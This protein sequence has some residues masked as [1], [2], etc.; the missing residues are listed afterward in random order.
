[1]KTF[2]TAVICLLAF[3]GK[4][5]ADWPFAQLSAQLQ[6]AQVYDP[7]HPTQ[8]IQYGLLRVRLQG[9]SSSKIKSIKI[10]V[11]ALGESTDTIIGKMKD[12][13]IEN[14]DISHTIEFKVNQ[15]TAEILWVLHDKQNMSFPVYVLSEGSDRYQQLS[16]S[17]SF[18]VEPTTI[19]D[20]VHPEFEAVEES[21]HP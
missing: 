7:E 19:A 21:K 12:V 2:L 10:E 5:L 3:N 15:P 13:I 16:Q 20:P 6:V 11:P 18:T 4:A 1:M 8:L 14:P 9:E 17:D